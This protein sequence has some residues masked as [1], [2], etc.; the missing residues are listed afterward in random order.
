VL[1]EDLPLAVDVLGDMITSSLIAPDDVEAEREVILDE[2]AMH[3]DDP[4]DVVTNLYAERSWGSSA[5]GRPIAGTATSISNLTRAQ[6]AR[7][8][9]TTYRPENMVVAVAGNVDHATVVRQ[10]RKAFARGNFLA[11]PAARPAPVRNGGRFRRANGGRA[12]VER[13]FEQANVILGVN[14]LA[15][16]DDRRYALGV[17]N[18]A[19]GGGPSSRL[20]QEVREQRGLAYSVYSYAAHYADAGAFCVGA[21]CLP[22]KLGDVLDVVRDELRRLAEHGITDDELVRGKGQLRG[23]LVLGLEDSAS[24]MSRIAKSEL[25]Y[26][27]LPSIDE[28]ISRIDAVTLDD[29]HALARTLFAQP[30][31]LAV[32]GPASAASDA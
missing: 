11:D 9:R 12:Y 16:N 31:T 29:V 5:L 27:D 25:L 20:F 10:V 4:E 30:E 22:N 24:R 26:D 19:L 28:V 32:V 3:D 18:A 7:F 15:R 21:G 13:P 2:I 17:L 6:I 8:Y 1:D 14:G 23:G